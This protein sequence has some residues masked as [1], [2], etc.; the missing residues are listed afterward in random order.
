MLLCAC[1]CNVPWC[2]RVQCM[3]GRQQHGGRGREMGMEGLEA[4][5]RCR[6]SGTVTR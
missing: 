1:V 4:G 3:A 2:R 5:R 6:H